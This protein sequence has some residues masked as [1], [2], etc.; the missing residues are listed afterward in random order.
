MG[1]CSLIFRGFSLTAHSDVA[2]RSEPLILWD[3]FIE[4]Y[5]KKKDSI[6]PHSLPLRQYEG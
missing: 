4:P 6:D 1:V 2:L 3:G 5:F